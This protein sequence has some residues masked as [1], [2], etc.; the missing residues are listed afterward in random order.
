M[1]FQI[2]R[3]GLARQEGNTKQLGQLAFVIVNLQPS[4]PHSLFHK[5][6]FSNVTPKTA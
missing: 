3:T 5:I 6:N 4:F 1:N 2:F